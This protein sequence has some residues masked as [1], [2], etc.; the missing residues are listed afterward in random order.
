ML[1][2]N[3]KSI[4]DIQSYWP[5]ELTWQYRTFHP[6]TEKYVLPHS[7][8]PSTLGLHCQKGRGVIEAKGKKKRER[9]SLGYLCNRRAIN[10]TLWSHSPLVILNF[11]YLVVDDWSETPNL[12]EQ[13]LPV[14][15]MCC[16]RLV[17]VTQAAGMA[18][19]DVPSHSST[20]V[21]S[22]QCKWDGAFVSSPFPK[23]INGHSCIQYKCLSILLRV[24]SHCLYFILEF[25]Y[26]MKII[27][28]AVLVLLLGIPY[29]VLAVI[30]IDLSVQY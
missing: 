27:S 2:K 30:I 13:F 26:L 16:R 6:T 25:H 19:S 11:K 8:L 9:G 12:T 28:L 15:L 21:I 4:K 1:I 7:A 17:V 18:A 20:R 29:P 24:L 14:V 10:S 23:L 22:P 5:L 3:R